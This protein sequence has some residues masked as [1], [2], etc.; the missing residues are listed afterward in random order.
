MKSVRVSVV[1]GVALIGV[2]AVL[3]VSQADAY[4]AFSKA[5]LK[6]YADQ[7]DGAFLEQEL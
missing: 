4:L 1:F 6:K 2:V 3:N 5:F 7:I